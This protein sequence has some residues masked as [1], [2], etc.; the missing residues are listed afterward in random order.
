MSRCVLCCLS[1]CVSLIPA[2]PLEIQIERRREGTSTKFEAFLHE[3]F[4]PVREYVQAV[5]HLKYLKP[6]V[7]ILAKRGVSGLCTEAMCEPDSGC[8]LYHFFPQ[9]IRFHTYLMTSGPR[10]AK[11]IEPHGEEMMWT[12]RPQPRKRQIKVDRAQMSSDSSE[13]PHSQFSRQVRS[14]RLSLSPQSSLSSSPQS[15]SRTPERKDDGGSGT[16]VVDGGAYSYA[17]LELVHPPTLADRRRLGSAKLRYWIHHVLLTLFAQT[18]KDSDPRKLDIFEHPNSESVHVLFA[19]F[20]AAER[21]V[22]TDVD[23]DILLLVDHQADA[24]A[25]AIA[26]VWVWRGGI[27]VS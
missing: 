1:V 26:E 3:K 2:H 11:C 18:E 6:I 9:C 12:L 4:Q 17:H 24:L 14:Q 21:E 23:T 15:R 27:D 8:A 5:D 25:T 7:L 10:G 13:G 16:S 19:R 20:L 22:S